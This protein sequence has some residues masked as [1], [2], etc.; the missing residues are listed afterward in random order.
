MAIPLPEVEMAEQQQLADLVGQ[1]VAAKEA[2]PDADTTAIEATIDNLVYDL[3]ELTEDEI[4]QV[5]A[6]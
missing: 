6:V 1:V 3:Y 2:D 5:E 4:E